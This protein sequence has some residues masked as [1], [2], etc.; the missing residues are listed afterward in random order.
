MFALS[1]DNGLADVLFLRRLRHDAHLRRQRAAAVNVG[2]GMRVLYQGQ[3]YD[4]A[5]AMYSMGAREYS[6]ALGGFSLD[7]GRLQWEK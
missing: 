6:P 4:P 3:L 7:P 2:L 5:L 1:G